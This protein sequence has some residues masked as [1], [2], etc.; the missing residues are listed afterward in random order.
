[1]RKASKERDPGLMWML[2]HAFSQVQVARL[3]AAQ[4]TS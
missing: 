2:V 3:D 4:A 1:M